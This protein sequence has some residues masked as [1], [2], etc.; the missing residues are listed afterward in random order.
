MSEFSKNYQA[1]KYQ[2]TINNPIDHG[3]TNE[4]ILSRVARL[5]PDYWC[6]VD[7]IGEQ[8]TPH[9]HIYLYRKSKTRAGTIQRLFPTAH[10]EVAYGSSVSNRDYLLKQGKWA[11]TKKAETTVDGTFE[12]HGDLPNER[13]EKNPKMAELL[14]DIENGKTTAQIIRDN[15]SFLLKTKD[16]ETTR[17][18]LQGEDYLTTFREVNT[19]YL[20]G[21]TGCG[22]TY[23]IFQKYKPED[24]CRITNYNGGSPRFDA[25][26]SQPVLVFE[27][28][29][30][31]VPVAEMLNYLDKYPLMLPA[32]YTDKVACYDTIYI[33]SNLSLRQQY[34]YV[35]RSNPEVW[36]AFLRRIDNIHEMDYEHT[37][38]PHKM[39]EYI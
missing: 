27:E 23:S 36:K 25:Y 15:P 37:I 31:Q 34:E 30:S 1:R 35:Q 11:D 20:Y 16:I 3:M 14:D 21:P 18:L 6:M 26:S 13:D 2:L 32:R 9:K 39:E 7:E 5:D 38:I 17:Q 19:T 10:I 22:K 8:G 12:E 28:F 4:E 29:H 24:I 33:T